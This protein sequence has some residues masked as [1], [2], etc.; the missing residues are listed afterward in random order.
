MDL[1][2]E[3]RC[4]LCVGIR[5]QVPARAG[6]L[7]VEQVVAEQQCRERA[8]G[9]GVEDVYAEAWRP[10]ERRGEDRLPIERVLVMPA[11][12][13]DTVTGLGSVASSERPCTA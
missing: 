5:L 8:G 10:E 2:R 12:L 4:D 3:H 11:T 13:A 1:L 6:R 9:V 7:G